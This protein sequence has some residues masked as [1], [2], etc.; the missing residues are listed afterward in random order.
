ML[1]NDQALSN[2]L[3]DEKFGEKGDG[4]TFSFSQYT[5]DPVNYAKLHSQPVQQTLSDP[6]ESAQTSSDA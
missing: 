1:E 3:N 6:K 2:T 4:F 5:I